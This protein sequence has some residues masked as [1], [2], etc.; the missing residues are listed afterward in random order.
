VCAVCY[1]GENAAELQRC[2]RYVVKLAGRLDATIQAVHTIYTDRKQRAVDRLLTAYVQVRW[3]TGVQNW[4]C[5]LCWRV[6]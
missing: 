5:I 2:S 3:P 6:C 4:V 1:V